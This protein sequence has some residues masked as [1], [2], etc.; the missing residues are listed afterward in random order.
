VKS[1]YAAEEEH[2][3]HEVPRV[4]RHSLT[5]AIAIFGLALVGT[6]CAVGYRNMFGGSVWPTITQSFKAINERNTIPSASDPQARTIRW[7]TH[8][9]IVLPFA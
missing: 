6:A 5:L 4:R 3:D 1:H 7:I 9:V 2:Q 8:V